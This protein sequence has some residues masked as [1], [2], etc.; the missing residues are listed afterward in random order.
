[1]KFLNLSIYSTI[2]TV[3]F[4]AVV[5]IAQLMPVTARGE[6]VPYSFITGSNPYGSGPVS[7]FN[8]TDFAAGLFMYDP[9]RVSS[10]TGSRG[11]TRYSGS[12]SALFAS[13]GAYNLSDP[14]GRTEVGNDID[15]DGA[16][17]GTTIA[18]FLTLNF[19]PD[20]GINLIGFTI[21]GYQLINV[22]FFWIEGQQG[23]TDFLTNQNLPGTLPTFQGT[24][25]L[26]FVSTVN[27]TAPAVY[28]FF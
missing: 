19:E 25:G 10:G 20:P 8:S 7:V 21:D 12:L 15:L 24:L 16:G 28:V 6:P 26:D 2:K 22:R 11:D 13:V 9:L 23:I 5:M 3:I 27:P 18:D 17:P 4:A 1:M 14:L